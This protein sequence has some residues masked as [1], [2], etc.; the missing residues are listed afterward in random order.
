MLSK[1]ICTAIDYCNCSEWMSRNMGE[2]HLKSDN[3][4]EVKANT[5]G[6]FCS[7]KRGQ[8]G[9]FSQPYTGSASGVFAF[10]DVPLCDVCSLT[11][12]VTA[13]SPPPCP[14]L[15]DPVSRDRINRWPAAVAAP[16]T[17]TGTSLSSHAHTYTHPS[18][19]SHSGRPANVLCKYDKW[20]QSLCPVFPFNAW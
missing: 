3:N 17:H 20:Q 10:E 19:V 6:N 1:N 4:K 8:I 14:D 12:R 7:R 9:L 2:R 13:F 15:A 5:W 16:P 11:P 18:P